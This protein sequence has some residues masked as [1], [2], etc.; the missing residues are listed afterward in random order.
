MIMIISQSTS[1]FLSMSPGVILR[2][3][4]PWCQ[5]PVDVQLLLDGWIKFRVRKPQ[6]VGND[7]KWWEIYGKLMDIEAVKK[8]SCC[9]MAGISGRSGG[10]LCSL[11]VRDIWINCNDLT[12]ALLEE[13]LREESSQY[14]RT[15]Q[16]SE[17][18]LP[19]Y[20]GSSSRTEG[21]WRIFTHS[22]VDGDLWG[23]TLG[24]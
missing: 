22:W 12:A 13:W 1:G 7:G 5:R 4:P 8:S 24:P 11:D 21:E 16:V 2:G 3:V 14:G 18:L 23:Q 15:I 17:I 10:V 19:R 9:E 20:M 6:S